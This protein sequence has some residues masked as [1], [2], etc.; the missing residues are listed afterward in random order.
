MRTCSLGMSP[1]IQ[2]I[3]GQMYKDLGVRVHYSE[4]DND[5]TLAAYA[6]VHGASVLSRDKDFF[7]YRN[8]TYKV[9]SNFE[10]KYGKLHL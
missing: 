7:R 9:Y 3:L 4:I 5:D 6:S 2:I 8:A 1:G 10:I